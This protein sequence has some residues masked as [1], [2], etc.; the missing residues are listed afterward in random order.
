[1][2]TMR[3][4]IMTNSEKISWFGPAIDEHEKRL[5]MDVLDSNYL[6]DGNVSRDLEKLI[7]NFVGSKYAVAT[8]SG[9][10]GLAMSL[11]ALGVGPGDEVIVPDFTFVATANAARFIGA[12]VRL[13]D[14]EP[15]RL[16]LDCNKLLAAITSK[17]KAIIAVDV[18]GRGADYARLEKICADNNIALICDSAEALGSI[19]NNQYLGTFGD[20]GCFSFSANKTIT[21]GQGGMIVTNNEN[22]YHRLREI[23][24]QGRRF[25]GSGGDDH[26]PV[27]GFNFKFTNIQA[28]I[29]V[30]QFDKLQSRLEHFKTRDS[31][32]RECLSGCPGIT[33][34]S[35]Y[36][37]TTE[38]CQWTDILCEDRKKI[39]DALTQNNMDH[40]AF[41]F[42]LHHQECY[43]GLNTDQCESSNKISKQGL[44]LPSAFDL[45][46]DQVERVSRV[47][48]E[49]CQ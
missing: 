14:I 3:N 18:N 6:N 36:N 22:L 24:D 17:T 37:Q 12:K 7:A 26:H 40:R 30:A 35:E 4:R 47:I 39:S 11:F 8:T 20:A 13:V 5:V 19:H 49:A 21:S 42:P 43:S 46:F 48:R 38:V 1:M 27:L 44:W 15:Q 28:A 29:A 41:W 16:A 45:T 32:Y 33:F 31:W 34:P 2:E 10:A 25:G 23:K 9:T